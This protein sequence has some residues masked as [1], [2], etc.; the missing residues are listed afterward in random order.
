MRGGARAIDDEDAPGEDGGC[1]LSL[2]SLWVSGVEG[3]SPGDVD[4]EAGFVG[5][6]ELPLWRKR[7]IDWGVGM[8]SWGET[9]GCGGGGGV[10]VDTEMHSWDCSKA[11]SSLPEDIGPATSGSSAVCLRTNFPFISSSVRP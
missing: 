5:N 8:L 4:A 1:R 6:G 10:G 7:A 2:R 3:E 9:A 11:G